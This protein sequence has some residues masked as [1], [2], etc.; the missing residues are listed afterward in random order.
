A[1]KKGVENTVLG[2]RTKAYKKFKDY[3]QLKMLVRKPLEGMV[4]VDSDNS[5]SFHTVRFGYTHFHDKNSEVAHW[6]EMLDSV[7]QKHIEKMVTESQLMRDNF[8]G[9]FLRLFD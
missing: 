3:L 2:F 1:I 4:V 6:K 8:L 5:F 7:I 9:I